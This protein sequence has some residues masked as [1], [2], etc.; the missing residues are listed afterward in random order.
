M[1]APTPLR[2]GH[3]ALSSAP[4]VDPQKSALARGQFVAM[5]LTMSWQLAVVVLVPVI[6]GVEIGKKLGGETAGVLVGLAIAVLGSIAVMWRTMQTA[7]RL[8]VPKLT[9]AQK[10]AVQKQYEQEDEDA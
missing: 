10:R 3:K 7:N 9:A 5:A 6:A 1:H 8:P 4:S 2:G